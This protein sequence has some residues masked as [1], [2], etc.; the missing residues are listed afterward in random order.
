MR[1]VLI[2]LVLAATIT[3]SACDTLTAPAE[4]V[5]TALATARQDLAHLTAL[6]SQLGP[7]D[8]RRADLTELIQ[9][10][11][12]RLAA[13]TAAE[14]HLARAQNQPTD[15]PI[16]Q[17]V[18]LAAP[19][20]PEPVRTPLLLGSGLAAALLRARQLKTAARSIAAGIDR[21]AKTDPALADRLD[22]HAETIRETQSKSAQRLI[23]EA[24]GQR[25]ARLPI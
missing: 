7:N 5:A 19:W 9:R 20:I 8:P 12:L 17:L 16:A 15:D 21:A 10:T 25:K 18:G 14:D 2:S 11:E 23:E 3:I 6:E 13:L 24:T 1:T 22:K 4:P